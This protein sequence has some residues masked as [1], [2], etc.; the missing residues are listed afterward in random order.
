MFCDGISYQR[1]LVSS[2]SL[3]VFYM[4]LKMNN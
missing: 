1:L 2:L 4:A 3:A